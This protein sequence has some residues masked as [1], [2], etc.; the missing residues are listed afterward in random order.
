V[1]PEAPVDDG[2][3]LWLRLVLY[4]F[5]RL[6]Q[7]EAT[8]LWRVP[9]PV[10]LLGG[11]PGGPSLA[12]PTRWAARVGSRPH[13]DAHFYL[14]SI[15]RPLEAMALDLEYEGEVEVPEWPGDIVAL[16]AALRAR[17]IPLRGASALAHVDLPQGTGVASTAALRSALALTMCDLREAELAASDILPALCAEGHDAAAHTAALLGE[18]GRAMLVPAAAPGSQPSP[19]QA[20]FDPGAAGL[21]LV[22]MVL[23][24]GGE[25][26]PPVNWSPDRSEDARVD[27]AFDVLS[28]GDGS[29]GAELGRLLTDSQKASLTARSPAD[30][31]VAVDSALAAGAHGARATSSTTALALV[32]TRSLRAVR[33]AV[34]AAFHERGLPSPRLLATAAWAAEAEGESLIA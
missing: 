19:R 18:Q 12:M 17:G 1:K 10:V 3:D 13:D 30:A 21:R 31:D 9:A 33:S 25:P 2:R 22:L 23:R 8:T 26:S 7:T 29:L 4:S 28:G 6:Y 24:A 14:A 5:G 11:R 20:P 32:P 15:N 34:A 27:E 16:C